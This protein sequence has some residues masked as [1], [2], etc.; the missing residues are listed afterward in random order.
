MRTVSRTIWSAGQHGACQHVSRSAWSMSTCQQVSRTTWSAGQHVYFR[1]NLVHWISSL[2]QLILWSMFTRMPPK[3]PFGH[4]KVHKVHVSMSA[5]Q[6]IIRTTWSE[7]ERD[8]IESLRW[9]K[10]IVRGKFSNL[11]F[12]H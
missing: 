6:H 5:C 3:E 9:A 11:Y 4:S 2:D 7:G 12:I 1:V 10:I 8:H